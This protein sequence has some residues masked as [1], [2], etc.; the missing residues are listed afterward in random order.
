MAAVTEYLNT[1]YRPDRDY[2]DGAV[3]E[4]N[5]GERDHSQPQALLAAYFLVRKNEWGLWALTEQRVQVTPHR[6]RIPDV[7][8]LH[9]DAPYE[10][11]VSVP[12]LICIEILSKDDTFASIVERLEDYLAM[13]VPNVWVIDPRTRR[14]YRYTADGFLTANDGI[15]R[16]SNPDLAVPLAALFD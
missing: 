9:A 6:F 4:R 8:V 2:V 3:L 10:Q 5:L 16:T 1:T 12:P 14:G 7:C 13:G 11:V 15:L